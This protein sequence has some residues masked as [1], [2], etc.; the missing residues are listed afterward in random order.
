MKVGDLVQF[1]K[2][3]KDGVK[4]QGIVLYINTLDWTAHVDPVK[5]DRVLSAKILW[6]HPNARIRW[7]RV[8]QLEVISENR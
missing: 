6:N 2:I 1:K 8:A 4:K 7:A 3:D 5:R